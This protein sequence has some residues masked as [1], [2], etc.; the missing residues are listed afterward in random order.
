MIATG[1]MS[2]NTTHIYD[3]LTYTL[4]ATIPVGTANSPVNSVKF[5]PNSAVLAVGYKNGILKLYTI[6]TAV[7]ATLT[8][9]QTGQNIIN[10]M[11]WTTD[12]TYLATCGNPP[13]QVKIFTGSGSSWASAA[14]YGGYAVTGQNFMSCSFTFDN[15]LLAASN[16][17]S[18]FFFPSPYSTPTAASTVSY[19]SGNSNGGLTCIAYRW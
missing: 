10:S 1:G 17:G 9:A 2:D 12:S 7:T 15:N 11:D 19:S 3:A 16:N 13:T 4:K 18:V 5:S 8:A 14:G 6:A